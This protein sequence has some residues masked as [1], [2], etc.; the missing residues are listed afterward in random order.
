MPLQEK[1][2]VS[3]AYILQKVEL[4]GTANISA[5]S[6]QLDVCLRHQDLEALASSTDKL[7]Y[8]PNCDLGSRFECWILSIWCT[9]GDFA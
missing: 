3:S 8:F 6:G 9:R 4:G 1:P 2:S 7:A 5:F